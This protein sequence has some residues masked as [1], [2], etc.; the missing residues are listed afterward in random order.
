M[1]LHKATRVE[2]LKQVDI[3]ENRHSQGHRTK[4]WA[5]LDTCCHQAAIIAVEAVVEAA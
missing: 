3:K 2:S 4:T 5:G 1:T